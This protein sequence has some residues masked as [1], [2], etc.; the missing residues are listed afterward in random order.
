MKTLI[1]I[2]TIIT[3]V[4]F[5]PLFLFQVIANA[6]TTYKTCGEL[7][8]VY[9]YGVGLEGAKNM[10]KGKPKASKHLVS[11][12]LYSLYIKMDRDKDNISCER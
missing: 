5:I 8:K 9:K 12:E 6:E 10:V 4:L 11:P 7:N 3:M 2:S 1:R